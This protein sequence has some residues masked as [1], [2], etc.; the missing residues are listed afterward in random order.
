MA[1]YRQGQSRGGKPMGTKQRNMNRQLTE[2]E[3]FMMDNGIAY[4]LKEGFVD[5]G[6]IRRPEPSFGAIDG[7]TGRAARQDALLEQRRRRV[8]AFNVQRGMPTGRSR[9]L[10]F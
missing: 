5:P 10:G 2:G 7:P 9:L 3:Q 4:G 6:S 1:I 8:G